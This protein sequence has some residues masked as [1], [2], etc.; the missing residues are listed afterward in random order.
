MFC[1]IMVWY[2]V[3]DLKLY[4]EAE[5]EESVEQEKQQQENNNKNKS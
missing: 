2:H 5:E 1:D 3:K 4:G